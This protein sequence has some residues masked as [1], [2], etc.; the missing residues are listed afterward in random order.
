MQCVRLDV[1]S[2]KSVVIGQHLEFCL[3]ASPAV[4]MEAMAAV[5]SGL[6]NSTRVLDEN[7]SPEEKKKGEQWEGTSSGGDIDLK[8]NPRGGRRP[9]FR[10]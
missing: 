1:V 8:N 7:G 9:S 6:T 10:A 2:K 3:P 5:I 4:K